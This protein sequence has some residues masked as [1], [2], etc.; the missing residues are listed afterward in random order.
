MNMDLIEMVLKRADNIDYAS[1]LTYIADAL[2]NGI[3][4]DL[5]NS[6]FF[7]EKKIVSHDEIEI[8]QGLKRLDY[9][10]TAKFGD[11]TILTGLTSLDIIENGSNKNLNSISLT[12][13]TNPLELC[14]DPINPDSNIKEVIEVMLH[15]NGVISTAYLNNNKRISIVAS[16]YPRGK[17]DVY[18][19]PIPHNSNTLT[20][21]LYDRIKNNGETWSPMIEKIGPL[22][23]LC[24]DAFIE[25]SK[26]K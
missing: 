23:M 11:N 14:C 13:S 9:A 21:Q 22:V 7:S 3:E 12:Y 10:S 4:M 26:T 18:N 16:W 19:N 5:K 6:L 24:K 20:S 25:Y 2:I 15:E 8:Y 1:R 17:F